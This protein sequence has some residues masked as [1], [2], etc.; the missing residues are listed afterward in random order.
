M[1]ILLTIDNNL[2][3]ID[4]FNKCFKS[5]LS[6][7]N[8]QHEWLKEGRKRMD[9]LLKP[10]ATLPPEERVMLTMELQSDIEGTVAKFKQLNE[11][12][13]SIQPSAEKEKSE[14]SEV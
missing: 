14:E 5:Y 6:S 10:E 13:M 11:I 3:L 4:E 1:E 9:S 12:W 8:E 2:K 7:V